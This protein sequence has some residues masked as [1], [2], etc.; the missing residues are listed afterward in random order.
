MKVKP[1]ISCV[2]TD[3]YRAWSGSFAETAEE[4]MEVI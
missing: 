4:N 2:Q 3:W 1:G